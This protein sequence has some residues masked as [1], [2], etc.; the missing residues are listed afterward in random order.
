MAGDTPRARRG[1]RTGLALLAVLG[2][3]GLGLLPTSMAAF[4]ATTS[5][6]ASSFTARATFGLTQTA[7]CFSHDGSGG[8]T[9]A[10]AIAAG[11]SAVVSPDGAHVYVAT[12]YTPDGIRSGVAQFSRNAAT[13]ALTQLGCLS[14]G[15]LAGC[16]AV[17]GAL[18]GVQDVAIS[19]D[20]RHVY[21]A[22]A[23]SS[24]ITALSRDP[25]TGVLSALAAPNRCLY[26]SAATAV[27]GCTSGRVLDGA[28]GVAVSPDGA[29]VY[30][31]SSVSD[32]VTVFARDSGTGA[33]TQLAG[34]AGC[35]TNSAVGGC[36]TGKG[37][38]GAAYLHLSPDGSSLYVASTTS[39]AVAVFQRDA[40]TGVLTQPAAPNACVYNNGST[41]ITGCTAVRGLSGVKN[42]A[43]APDGRTAYAMAVSGDNLAAFTRNTGTGVLTQVAAPNAC[44]YRV[45]VVTGCTAANGLDGPSAMAFS[46]DGLFAFVAASAYNAVLTF[47]HDNTTGVLTQLTGTAGCLKLSGGTGCTTG[48]GLSRSNSVA[49]SPDGRD[50]YAVGGNVNSTGFV[51]PLNLAH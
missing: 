22:G 11:R 51:V 12:S 35:V 19:P 45:T 46:P 2:L 6:P 23:T 18:N 32:S 13:G 44:L 43:I 1:L 15:T 16:T 33:L 34:T 41:A 26:H 42:V 20:G 9:A 40:G 36:A 37:L 5:N 10:T 38:N 29:F 49:T 21:A 30:V 27:S 17:A 28:G 50:V 4:S 25:G 47:R 14:N 8:C 24:T 39:N 3:V 7:P 48:L 31:A